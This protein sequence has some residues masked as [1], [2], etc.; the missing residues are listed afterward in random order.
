MQ[1]PECNSEIKR[2]VDELRDGEIIF[3]RKCGEYS[4]VVFLD[5]GGIA[6]ELASDGPDLD[7]YQ[8]DAPP[9]VDPEEFEW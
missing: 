8:D 1:C 2:R 5:G 3:C 6:L 9:D 7:G 4:E